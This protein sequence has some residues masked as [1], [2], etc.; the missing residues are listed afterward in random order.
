MLVTFSRTIFFGL[1]S[2]PY[3]NNLNV[4]PSEVFFLTTILKTVPPSLVILFEYKL[5]ESGAFVLLAQDLVQCL[6][7]IQHSIDI[8]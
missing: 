6:A 7:H 3:E 8:W 1:L 4:I 5:C 2:L